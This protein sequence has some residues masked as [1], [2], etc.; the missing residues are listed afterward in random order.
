MILRRT[1]PAGKYLTDHGVSPIDFNTYGAR[2]GNHE[3][4]LRGTFANIRIKNL[5]SGVTKE[6][7][8][9]LHIPT[10]TEMSIYDAAMLYKKSE[11]DTVVIA[12]KE[13]GSGSSRDWAAK[14][15]KLLGIKAVIAES[16]ERIHR[17]N[18][19]GMGVMPLEFSDGQNRQTLHLSGH[20]LVS[21][22]I[23]DDL[24]VPNAIVPCSIAKKDGSVLKINLKSR[25]DTTAEV[26]Y[27]KAGGILIYALK[28]L[29]K[30]KTK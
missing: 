10:N 22:D 9:T 21:I 7:G 30:Y 15:V 18:L 4:M 2:R 3:V 27:Y 6:G 8:N 23:N 26:S 16:F 12:G 29:A 24:L 17:S 5:I 11:T 13:Y 14:G 20:E 25:I 19:I 28:H 1:S